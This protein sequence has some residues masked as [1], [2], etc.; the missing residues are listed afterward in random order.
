MIQI[1]IST[2]F[3]QLVIYSF[4]SSQATQVRWCCVCGVPDMGVAG[5]DWLQ[6]SLRLYAPL[7]DTEVLAAV[8]G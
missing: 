7:M 1:T 4:T 2:C 3:V 8:Q 6:E 5:L